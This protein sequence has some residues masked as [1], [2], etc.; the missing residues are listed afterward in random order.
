MDDEDEIPLSILQQ[1]LNLQTSLTFDDYINVDEH[2]ITSEAMSEEDIL[3]E[4][5][6]VTLPQPSDSQEDEEEVEVP[7]CSMSEAKVHLQELRRYF[8]SQNSTCDAD[9]DFLHR[10]DSALM[11]NS[12]TFRQS[13]IESYFAPI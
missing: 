12:S 4:A 5:T 9:I 7:I 13:T 11:K 1:R 8:F 10:L 3:S 2:V 6:S